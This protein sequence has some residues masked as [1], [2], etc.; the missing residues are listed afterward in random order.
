MIAQMG[1]ERL[2]EIIRDNRNAAIAQI[3]EEVRSQNETP[4]PSGIASETRCSSIFDLASL[5]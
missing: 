1:A 3:M 4:L 2:L 5:A